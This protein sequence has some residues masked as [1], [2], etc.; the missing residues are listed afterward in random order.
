MDARQFWRALFAML[1]AASASLLLPVA[2]AAEA[3]DWARVPRGPSIF[4]NGSFEAGFTPVIGRRRSIYSPQ[5]LNHRNIT[6]KLSAHGKY[7]L[8]LP[9]Y[10]NLH[11]PATVMALPYITKPFALKPGTGYVFSC[12]ARTEAGTARF[13]LAAALPPRTPPGMTAGVHTPLVD[14]SQK[15]MEIKDSGWTL[16]ETFVVGSGSDPI[17]FVITA[18]G[19][20]VDAIALRPLGKSMEQMAL[21]AAVAGA[22]VGAEETTEA[23]ELDEDDIEDDLAGGASPQKLTRRYLDGYKTRTPWEVGMFTQL[24]GHIFYREDRVTLPMRIWNGRDEPCRAVVSFEIVD[25]SG[26]VWRKGDAPAVE[27]AASGY[28]LAELELGTMPHGKYSIVYHAKPWPHAVDELCF[29]VLPKP[30]PGLIGVHGI[31][32]TACEETLSVYAR[33]GFGW[34]STLTDHAFR[35]ERVWSATDGIIDRRYIAQLIK[36]SGLVAAMCLEPPKWPVTQ[37]TFDLLPSR[38]P[39]PLPE[40]QHYCGAV[41]Q[42]AEMYAPYFPLWYVG[43]EVGGYYHPESYLPFL[44]E[45]AKTIRSVDPKAKIL[46]S[47]DAPWF[48]RFFRAGGADVIDYLGGS[49]MGQAGSDGRKIGWMAHRYG[50]KFWATGGFTRETT[51]YR[52]RPGGGVHCNGKFHRQVLNSFFCQHADGTSPYIGRPGCESMTHLGDPYNIIEHDGSL[53]SA[54]ALYAIAGTMMA[55]AERPFFPLETQ[56]AVGR[57]LWP[58][59]CVR[60]GRH[61]VCIFP[62][63]DLTLEIDCSPDQVE[64][65]DWLFNPTDQAEALDGKTRMK[66]GSRFWFVYDQGL[67]EK[68]F[69]EMLRAARPFPP[70]GDEG[71]VGRYSCYAT[72]ADGGL[73]LTTTWYNRGTTPRTCEARH[74]K[75]FTLPPGETKLFEADA[76]TFSKRYPM[77]PAVGPGAGRHAWLLPCP[78]VSTP[79][80]LDGL[81]DEWESRW[82][83]SLYIAYW[84]L[85]FLDQRAIHAHRNT[86]QIMADYGK[87]FRVDWWCAWDANALHLAAKVSD[88]QLQFGEA[89]PLGRQDHLEVRLWPELEAGKL[90]IG[91]ELGVAIKPT[92]GHRLFVQIAGNPTEL[93]GTWRPWSDDDKGYAGYAVEVSLPWRAL[94]YEPR[95]GALLGIDLFGTD[96]DLYGTWVEDSTL[97]WA[98]RA[99]PAGQAWLCE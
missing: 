95:S 24:P 62:G 77:L 83:A 68:R 14:G 67:G 51:F 84:Y 74:L 57:V 60:T 8:H 50:K 44:R 25:Q 11:D 37:Q 80:S 85:Q 65:V 20:F 75:A 46:V 40:I 73:K 97:R 1:T 18:A 45:V 10:T 43:D 32:T 42:L 3:A 89:T 96:V 29:D 15:S 61:A 99:E 63:R 66:L 41:R 90:A 21:D 49:I 81:L 27:V 92:A 13:S 2:G 48:D 26:A 53:T 35:L 36:D 9:K 31:H 98:G 19:A 47:A 88:D 17:H 39:G 69:Y 22:E 71:L 79:P 52:T 64:L 55:G 78:K 82:S 58:F 59:R 23:D 12:L 87:D 76:E 70:L 72:A 7:A 38:H 91:R 6:D 34:Y 86:F 56:H 16:C 30:Q 93:S 33:A 94:R 5:I 4:P 28:A 54:A